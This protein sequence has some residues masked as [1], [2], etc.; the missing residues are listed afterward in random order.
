MKR[1]F[2]YLQYLLVKG[3]MR[4]ME[5]M[6]R[7]FFYAFSGL[8]SRLASPLP[9]FGGLVR[10]NLRCAFPEKSEREI[11]VMARESLKSLCLTLCEFF[12]L[13]NKPEKVRELLE[14][15]PELQEVLDDV[16]EAG[17]QNRPV[18][19]ITPHFGNWELS[20]M[21]LA[22]VFGYKMATVVRTPRNP[23]LDR[24]ISGG[25]AV[26]NVKII[27]SRGGMLELVRDMENGYCAGMLIDQNTKVRSGGIFVDFFGF[28]CPVS[29]FPATMALKKN[30]Y[31]AIGCCIRKKDGKF[32]TTLRRMPKQTSEYTD[33]EEITQDITRV[34]E[35]LIRLA[36]EQYLWFYKRFQYIP[37]GTP[38]AERKRFPDYAYEPPPGFYSN[39]ER[40]KERRKKKSC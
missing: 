12:W 27:H 37:P 22:L 3:F 10:T 2:A 6:P 9:A 38:E 23:Y 31:I 20:G 17:K 36:P 7:G 4:L 28:P 34:S 13:H 40:A 35:E 19:F 11:R 14:I 21:A 30:A 29:R 18:I 1:F 33:E 39:A 24:L 25:R 15:Q 16:A 8:L 32:F 5:L 26:Q